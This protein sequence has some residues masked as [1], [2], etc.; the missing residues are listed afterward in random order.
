MRILDVDQVPA[1]EA[2]TLTPHLV[3][4]ETV[5]AAY[6][7]AT[8]AVL[9][10]ERRILLV[11]RE[12]LLIEKVETSSWPWRSVGHFAITEAEAA[13]E[14]RTALRVWLGSEPHPLH[15]RANEGTDLRPLQALLAERLA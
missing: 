13:E 8:A 10:T 3:P 12:A 7:S 14:S 4:G 5:L 9:F 11:F 15:L 6:R 2:E 1:P